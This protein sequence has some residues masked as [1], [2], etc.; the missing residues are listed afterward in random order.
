[1]G[2]SDPKRTETFTE[3]MEEHQ[4]LIFKVVCAYAKEP[5]DRDDLFQEIALQVWRSIP[6]FR[7]DCAESTWVYRVALNSAMSWSRKQ[8]R[9]RKQKQSLETTAPELLHTAETEDP[10]LDWLYEQI[11]KMPLADR[12][13]ILLLLDG[14]SYREMVDISGLSESHVGVKIHRIKQ[15]LIDKLKQENIHELHRP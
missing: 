6:K 4:K 8:R 9:H 3:W 12:S 11:H 15:Q 5:V 1:M 10:R 2:N 13:I 14:Y 7:G